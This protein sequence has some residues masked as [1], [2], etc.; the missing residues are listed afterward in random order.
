MAFAG[1]TGAVGTGGGMWGAGGLLGGRQS[2]WGMSPETWGMIGQMGQGFLGR[3]Q[4]QDAQMAP[5]VYGGLAQQP[6]P[7]GQAVSPQRNVM[8]VQG[9]YGQDVT[10]VR[11]MTPF[12]GAG[13]LGGLNVM[14]GEFDWLYGPGG[15]YSM[16]GTGRSTQHPWMTPGFNPYQPHPLA[17]A[18][19][20][21]GGG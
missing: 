13:Q 5:A 10:G 14:P 17:A 11:G 7:R 2:V 6:W 18:G 12:G 4:G 15:G 16:L 9:L 3:S 21:G 1:G 20:M 8:G 19:R